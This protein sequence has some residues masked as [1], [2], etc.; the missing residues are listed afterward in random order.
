MDRRRKP[1]AVSACL[2]RL[3]TVLGLVWILLGSS[4]ACSQQPE[5]GKVSLWFVSPQGVES[6]KFSMEVAATEAQ[7][8]IG[9]MHRKALGAH[10]GM[11]FLFPGDSAVR[12]FWMKNTYVSLDMA[13]VS[14]DW[15]VVG[16]LANVPPLTEDSRTIGRPSQYVLEFP[17][18]TMA[19]L[20]IGPDWAVK[21]EG[22]LPIAQW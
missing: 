3:I 5:P 8:R 6:P 22:K 21:T 18:G 20:G 16:I 19:T 7:R 2:T 9:L 1:M 13:F 14:E 11:I 4:V 17:A 12:A 10:N 15:K